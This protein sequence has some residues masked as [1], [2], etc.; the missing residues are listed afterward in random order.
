MSRGLPGIAVVT[1][2]GTALVLGGAAMVLRLLVASEA[3]VE[4]GGLL[5]GLRRPLVGG[6]R[7]VVRDLVGAACVLGALLGLG[8]ALL[9][10]GG[11]VRRVQRVAGAQL[12]EPLGGL[13]AAS[14]G[15]RA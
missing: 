6:S 15:G 11:V 2:R 7:A 1:L 14:P 13:F 3:R 10:P 5:V 9:L 8:R 4:L 12:L